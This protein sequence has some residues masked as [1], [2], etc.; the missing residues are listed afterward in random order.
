MIYAALYVMYALF[1]GPLAALRRSNE[2]VRGHFEL[3]FLTA[4]VADAGILGGL[5]LTGSETWGQWAG[6]TRH[7]RDTA[8]GLF[9]DG[10]HL[11]AAATL[12]KYNAPNTL[13]PA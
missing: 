2:L 4:A 13:L 10:A 11:R 9:R 3:V 12:V 1:L 5:A 6:L 8:G 7:R